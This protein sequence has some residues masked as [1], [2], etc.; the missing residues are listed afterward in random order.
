MLKAGSLVTDAECISPAMKENMWYVKSGLEPVK[1]NMK[2]VLLSTLDVDI[3][4]SASGLDYSKG[5]MTQE[6]VI[7]KEPL[8]L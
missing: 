7:Q 2:K 8:K 1:D 4:T 6:D 5:T 3:V